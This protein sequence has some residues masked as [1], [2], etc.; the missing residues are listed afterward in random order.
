MVAAFFGREGERASYDGS[1]LPGSKVE[2]ASPVE[3]ELSV[4]VLPCGPLVVTVVPS[5]MPLDS[6]SALVC[7][8]RA[9]VAAAFFPAA[10]RDLVRAALRPALWRV[11]VRAALRAAARRLRVAA[12]FCPAVLGFDAMAEH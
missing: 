1:S 4:V 8:F 7:L 12:A 5:D 9:R 6:A 2:L 11:R 3:C 10:R